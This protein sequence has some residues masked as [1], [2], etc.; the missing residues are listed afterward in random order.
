[1][2][3]MWRARLSFRSPLRSSRWRMVW[4]E[5]AGF[6]G[7]A[8]QV[9]QLAEP[10][11]LGVDCS[12]S[13]GHQGLQALA[14]TAGSRRRRPLLGKHAAGGADRVQGVGLAARAT[15]PPQPTDL[16]HP[17]AAAG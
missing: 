1:M 5:E 16:E 13:G 17:L 7:C 11:P 2:R 9:A 10:G 12:F 3:I 14:F 4:P 6:G 15:L 8:Q